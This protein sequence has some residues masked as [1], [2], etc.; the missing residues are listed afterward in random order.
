[1]PRLD[2][3]FARLAAHRGILPEGLVWDSQ[4]GRLSWVDIELG[5]LHVADVT[6]DHVRPL[7]VLDLGDQL[8]CAL[9]SEDGGWICGLGRSLARVSPMGVIERSAPILRDGERFNDGHIDPKG[10]LVIGSLRTAGPDGRQVIVRLESDGALTLLDDALGISNGIG[11]SPDGAVMYNAD[12]AARTIT[13]RC[14][15]DRV[16]R[17]T[18]LIEVG[19]MPDGIAVDSSGRIWVTVFD[20]GRVDCYSP[21]GGLLPAESIVVPDAHVASVAFGGGLMFIATGMP[22]MANWLRLRRPGDGFILYQPT[23]VSQATL[24]AWTPTPLPSHLER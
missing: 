23:G 15:G 13:T 3:P 24:R 14:Y 20:Q 1:M 16:G 4:R 9:P 22:I 17:P 19:G 11:W 2:A 8:G 21:D 6:D 5:T 18:T 12:T 10:R 7:T